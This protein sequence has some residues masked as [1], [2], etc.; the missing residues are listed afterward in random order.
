V[1]SLALI[2]YGHWG[3]HLAR[4]LT[5]VPGARLAM[6]SDIRS[7]QL[8]AARERFPRVSTTADPAQVFADPSVDAVAIATPLSSHY[9]LAHAALLAGKHVLVEKPMTANSEEGARLTELA[10]RRRLVLMVNHVYAYAEPVRALRALL[11]DG[12][13]GKPYYYDSVRINLGR[14]QPDIDALWDLA[15]H[16]LAI[17]DRL[18]EEPPSAV[19][20]VGAAHLSPAHMSIAYLTLFYPDRLLAHV[21]VNWL[22]PVKV[23]RI[24]LGGSEG[25]AVIDELDRAEQV[26]IFDR[27]MASE[28]DKNA[29]GDSR[30]DNRL[31]EMRS[32][33]LPTVEPL[34]T[35]VRH[36]ARCIE[37]GTAPLTDGNAGLRVV[38][39]LEMASR[40]L[41]ASGRP[42]ELSS[43][44][45]W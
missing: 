9:P 42:V 37:D 31:G 5:D 45:P 26:K 4:N 24:I 21:H 6:V 22:S 34:S 44:P 11:R 41:A 29:T 14:F 1:I 12:T 36:F 7:E 20:A 15:T 30:F 13:I 40:S 32:P 23:R 8:A 3:R 39:L 2:G 10:A 19:S 25:F 16:D 33:K 35:A 17:L 28:L 43:V 18:F 27:L 38:R